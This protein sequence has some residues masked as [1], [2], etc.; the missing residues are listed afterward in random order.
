SFANEQKYYLRQVLLDDNSPFFNYE[1]GMSWGAF[2]DSTL[3]SIVVHPN[4]YVVGVNYGLHKMLILQLPSGAVPDSDAPVALP[5]SGKGLREGL[6]AGP[7]AL[8]VTPDGRILVLEQDNAR[9]QAFDTMANPVQCFDGPLAFNVD[10]QFK[11]DLNSNQISTAFQQAYQKSVQPQLAASFSLPSTLTG[12]LNGGTVTPDLKQQFTN[13]GMPLSDSGPYQLLTTVT[14]SVWLLIDQGS[15]VSY[16]IRKNLYVNVG[17]NEIMTLPASLISDLNKQVA[18]AALIQEFADYGVNLS[19]PDKL[20]VIMVTENSEWLVVD[21]DVTYDITVQSNA[22]AYLGSTLLFNLPVG[23]LSGFTQSGPPP[24]DLVDLFTGRGVKLSTSLQLNIITP[25]TTWQLVDLGNNVTYDIDT[26]ADLDVFHAPSFSVEVIAQN[27]HWL[28]R[29]TVNTL[30]FDIT[31]DTTNASLLD[32]QQLVS[33]MG[34]K[35]GVSPNIHYL[36]VGVETKGFIY[37]LSYQGTG[38]APSDYHLDI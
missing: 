15:G 25:G 9:I 24:Q 19:P 21:G 22:Y 38:S 10:A 11:A 17:G 33:V 6:V 32:V 5:M 29:D 18:S 8:N 37:V 34:L 23:F 12:T 35:D 27:T 2:A 14:D 26:E 30:S 7:V 20:Q 16:G 28:L 1:P 31:P 13:N 36:D 3:D 4:G